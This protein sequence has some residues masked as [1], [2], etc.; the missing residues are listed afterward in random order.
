MVAEG[1]VR[2]RDRRAA[3]DQQEDGVGARREYQLELGASSRVEVATIAVRESL[4]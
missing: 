4:P 2:R 1:P 3:G